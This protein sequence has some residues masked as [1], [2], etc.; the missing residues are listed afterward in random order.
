MVFT[1]TLSPPAPDAPAT[2]QA[3]R[4]SSIAEAVELAMSAATE[5]LQ[6]P[7]ATWSL[8]FYDFII[9][10]GTVA[11]APDGGV[12]YDNQVSHGVWEHVMARVQE[13]ALMLA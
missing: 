3:L 9:A 5:G 11:R 2:Q 1:L 12:R 7:S 13:S 8:R 10:T 4:A 6:T